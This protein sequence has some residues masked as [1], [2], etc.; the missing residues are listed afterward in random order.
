MDDKEE[1]NEIRGIYADCGFLDEE[2]LEW[3]IDKLDSFM[4]DPLCPYCLKEIPTNDIDDEL[5]GCS[6]VYKCPHCHKEMMVGVLK[7]IRYLT[8]KR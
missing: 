4:A 7:T 2:Y 5:E 1:Y 3:V 8:Y 6:G